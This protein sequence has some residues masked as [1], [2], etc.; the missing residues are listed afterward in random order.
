MKLITNWA[1]EEVRERIKGKVLCGWGRAYVFSI[2]RLRERTRKGVDG[3]RII[4]LAVRRDAPPGDIA[5]FDG[6]WG[7]YEK[8]ADWND[9]ERKVV[10]C[11]L[12]KFN[13]AEVKD[14]GSAIRLK[15]DMDSFE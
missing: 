10:G 2:V 12:A 13:G 8:P 1:A 14:G 6:G 5:R 11:I 9:E 15:T 4:K 7:D 3:G